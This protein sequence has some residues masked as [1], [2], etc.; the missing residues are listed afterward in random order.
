MFSP[1]A[2][3][4]LAAP[5]QGRNRLR[6]RLAAATLALVV[7]AVAWAGWLEA[8]GVATVDGVKLPLSTLAKAAWDTA[9]DDARV[10]AHWHEDLPRA[11]RPVVGFTMNMADSGELLDYLVRDELFRQEAHRRG[12]AVVDSDLARA[13]ALF[14][15]TADSIRLRRAMVALKVTRAVGDVA[16]PT[17][18]E[19]QAYYDSTPRWHKL[20]PELA[21]REIVLKDVRLAARLRE[22]A[23]RGADFAELARRHSLWEAVG[24][25][26]DPGAIRCWAVTTVG[27]TMLRATAALRPGEV[28]RPI[29]SPTGLVRLVQLVDRY[30]ARTTVLADVSDRV[31]Q[32]LVRVR[33][34]QAV[35]AWLALRNR[36]A[37]RYTWGFSAPE[38]GPLAP[39]SVKPALFARGW[40]SLR[41]G[42]GG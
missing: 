16:R 34:A 39:A 25:S 37:V 20:P 14:G 42:A 24:H 40:N 5:K 28:S 21:Y 4:G 7:P 13:H 9:V 3:R 27:P 38:V 35:K 15:L 12:L 41:V 29:V 10:D 22:E 18:A 30:P 23:S 33:R 8:R 1:F 19:L 2:N 6:T 36:E 17:P 11:L 31:T 32:E 26:V